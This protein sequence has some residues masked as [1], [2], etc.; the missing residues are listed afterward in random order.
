MNNLQNNEPLREI[1]II[2]E[3]ARKRTCRTIADICAH[4]DLPHRSSYYEFVKSDSPKPDTL[5]RIA[6]GVGITRE[7]ADTIVD[8]S[9]KISQQWSTIISDIFDDYFN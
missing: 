7:E 9:S 8:L 5:A 6:I 4:A 1:L 3:N 2:I